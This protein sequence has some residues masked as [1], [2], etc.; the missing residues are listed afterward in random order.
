[1][2]SS[3]RAHMRAGWGVVLIH[4][5]GFHGRVRQSGPR[6]LRDAP[7]QRRL[8]LA[9]SE[10]NRTRWRFATGNDRFVAVDHLMGPWEVLPA[11][12]SGVT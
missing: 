3:V 8:V 4:G 6:R 11:A 10:L 5:N 1:M 7:P 12:R 2:A 9:R